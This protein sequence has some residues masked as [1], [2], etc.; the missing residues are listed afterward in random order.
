VGSVSV[1]VH[2]GALY[3]GLTVNHFFWRFINKSR[4][5]CVLVLS[6]LLDC[7]FGIRKCSTCMRLWCVCVCESVC[8]NNMPN[9]CKY[10][11]INMPLETSTLRY[12]LT[13]SSSN[14]WQTY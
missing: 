6:L 8:F 9:F 12:F 13:F 2:R 1:M 11:K 3:Q 4:L 10:G 5:I 7:Y 14:Q